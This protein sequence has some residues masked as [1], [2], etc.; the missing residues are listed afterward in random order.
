MYGV[1]DNLP[2]SELVGQECIQILLGEFQISFSFADGSHI[3]TEGKWELSNRDNVLVDESISHGLR[4][5]YC[6]HKILGQKVESFL[7][8]VPTCFTLKFENH[9][10]LKIY[11]DSEHY[12][13]FALHLNSGYSIYV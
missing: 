7:I 9:L 12:E 8:N 3:S 5:K 10:V 11:D 13:S 6:I 2:L 1:P 4:E